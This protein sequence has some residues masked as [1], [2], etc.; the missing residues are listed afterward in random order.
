[1]GSWLSI[2]KALSLCQFGFSLTERML[3]GFYRMALQLDLVKVGL[4]NEGFAAL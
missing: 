2:E 3:S 4:I 1:L